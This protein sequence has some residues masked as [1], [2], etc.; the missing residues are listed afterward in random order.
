[1]IAFSF[2]EFGSDVAATIAAECSGA[3][4][5]AR[6]LDMNLSVRIFTG[7]FA[8][9]GI[10]RRKRIGEIRRLDVSRLWAQGVTAKKHATYENVAGAAGIADLIAKRAR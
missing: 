8:V 9:L 5:M 6:G 4:S 1:M 3:K 2:A 7:A 10:M